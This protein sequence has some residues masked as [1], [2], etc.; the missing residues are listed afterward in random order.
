VI[1]ATFGL[2]NDHIV[3][4]TK[5][6]EENRLGN[7]SQALRDILDKVIEASQGEA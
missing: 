6:R 2:G 3:F 1:P 4:I 7:N 5:W